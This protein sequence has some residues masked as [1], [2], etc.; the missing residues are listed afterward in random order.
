MDDRKYPVDYE[1]P[2]E[3]MTDEQA[4]FIIDM[5]KDVCTNVDKREK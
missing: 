2:A 4:Q 1:F 5:L 3:E